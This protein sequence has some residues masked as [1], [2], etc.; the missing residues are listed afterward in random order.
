MTLLMMMMMMM[1]LMTMIDNGR[2]VEKQPGKFVGDTGCEKLP[3]EV[4]QQSWS[5]KILIP[6]VFA[7]KIF[8]RFAGLVALLRRVRRNA[9][10]RWPSSLKKMEF[11]RWILSY[12]WSDSDPSSNQVIASLVDVPEEICDLNPQKT[13]RWNKKTELFQFYSLQPRLITKLVPKLSPKHECT[14]VPQVL[15]FSFLQNLT[16]IMIIWYWQR[17]QNKP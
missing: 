2:Y 5:D 11:S 12:I 3:V 6:G 8:F 15:I 9:M 13:C 4:Q 10:T 16:R 1:T 14:I 17:G 7:K